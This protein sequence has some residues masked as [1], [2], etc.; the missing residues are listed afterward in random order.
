MLERFQVTEADLLGQGGES[1]VYA[2]GGDRV[3]RVY[4]EGVAPAYIERRRAFY[5]LLARFQ[6]PFEVPRFLESGA[7]AGRSYAIERR[8]RGRDFAAV[9]PALEGAAREKALAS[10]AEVAWQI[11]T[12]QFPDQPFGEILTP[13]EPLQ[14]PTWPGFLWDRMQQALDQSRPN[15]ERDVPRLDEVLKH[16]RREL[17][18]LEGFA[19]RRLVHGDYFPGNVF[20]DDDLAICGVGDFGYT[21]VLGDARM[22]LA[23]AVAYLEVMEAHRPEDTTF[24]T[25]VLEER[26]GREVLRFLQLYRLY[27]SVYF[28]VCKGLDDVTYAWCVRNLNAQAAAL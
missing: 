3:L 28:S 25:G 20:I 23:G 21:T 5:E 9:L 16:I 15:L 27:Y 18:R 19:E 6:P 12:V 2:L 7:V 13:G 26:H 14:R 1:Q 10:F 17:A 11:G 8:M 22:D 24:L 4:K